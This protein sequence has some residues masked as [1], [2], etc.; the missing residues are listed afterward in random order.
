M[1]DENLYARVVE[2]LSAQG[3]VRGLWAKAYAESNGNHEAARALYLRLRVAQLAD[4][5]LA[6]AKDAQRQQKSESRWREYLLIAGLTLFATVV[7]VSAVVLD[8]PSAVY[9]LANRKTTAGIPPLTAASGN[10]P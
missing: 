10:S 4:E 8:L 3:P 6:L 1:S 9:D 7:V 5:R 2:E